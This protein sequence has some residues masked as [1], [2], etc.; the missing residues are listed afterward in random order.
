MDVHKHIKE[1]DVDLK[2]G[3]QGWIQWK[4]TSVCMDL[5][6]ECG[7][8]GHVDADFFYFYKCSQCGKRYGVGQTVKLIPLEDEMADTLKDWQYARDEN[9]EYW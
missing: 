6:C 7:H 4:G 5:F 2:D 3:P 8:H 9:E 1:N